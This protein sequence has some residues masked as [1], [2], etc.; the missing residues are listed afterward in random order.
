MIF[1]PYAPGQK[2]LTT[3]I[4]GR[5]KQGDWGAATP[6]KFVSGGLAPLKYR[7]GGTRRIRERLFLVQLRN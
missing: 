4:Q 6:L 3:P 5:R 2:S 7:L 1:A